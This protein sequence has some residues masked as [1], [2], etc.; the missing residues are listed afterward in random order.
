MSACQ[1]AFEQM[2]NPRINQLAAEHFH[3][4]K[5]D[6]QDEHDKQEQLNRVEALLIFASQSGQLLLPTKTTCTAAKLQAHH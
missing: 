3:E 2:H 5:I 1:A 4:F 6:R